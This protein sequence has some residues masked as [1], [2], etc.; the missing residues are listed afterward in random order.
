M[1]LID[2]LSHGLA[3]V[4]AVLFFLSG[5]FLSYEV[6]ARYLF[7]APTR[8]VLETCELLLMWGTFLAL[9]RLI[10][11]REN[12]SIEILFDRLAPSG[13]RFLDVLSLLFMAGFAAVIGVYSFDI[14][15]DS[16]VTRRTTATVLDYPNW[17]AEASIVVGMSLIVLQCLVELARALTGRG[18]D[19]GIGHGHES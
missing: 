14:A 5:V 13:Q 12:I 17:W 15:Y 1:Q 18:W 11:L 8:W 16:Y 9:G 3:W 10:H 4:A 19:P 7:N 2:R 6:A